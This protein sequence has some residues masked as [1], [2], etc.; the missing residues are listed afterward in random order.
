MEDRRLFGE[1]YGK[2]SGE[3]NKTGL[4]ENE[5]ML[6]PM[7]FQ[8]LK[9]YS[10]ERCI[11]IYKKSGKEIAEKM[12]LDPF[13]DEIKYGKN[14]VNWSNPSLN[15]KYFLSPTDRTKILILM[16]ERYGDSIGQN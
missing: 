2:S 4:K 3:K 8:A 15:K 5:K 1:F 13:G 10:Q 12:C 14:D 16:R 11:Q 6:T 9:E 7:S